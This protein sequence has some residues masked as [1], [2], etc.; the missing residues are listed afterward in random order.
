MESR[1][2]SVRSTKPTKLVSY[3]N[4]MGHVYFAHQGVTKTGKPRYFA[5]QKS[6]GAMAKL[7]NGFVFGESINGVVT[8]QRPKPLRVPEADIDLV[9]QKVAEFRHLKDYRVEAK[10]KSILIY[11]PMG[12]GSIA[13]LEKMTAPSMFDSLKSMLGDKFDDAMEK[14]AR[15][16]GMSVR[17]L[18]RVDKLAA[19]QKRKRGTEYLIRNI[20]YDAVMRF[21]LDPLCGPYSV[22]RRC[23]R[24]EEHWASLG[25]GALDKMLKKYVRHIGKESFFELM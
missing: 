24:G 14:T 3:T 10:D 19:E 4:R 25:F 9:R 18:K 17:D 11:E 23:Y 2:T 21:T 13:T 16:M 12:M 1:E 22:E 8:L 7:P 5:S 20:Q 15:D 6:E